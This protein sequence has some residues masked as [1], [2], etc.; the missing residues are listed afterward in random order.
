[1]KKEYQLNDLKKLTNKADTSSFIT[2][3]KIETKSLDITK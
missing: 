2:G 1:M 3:K